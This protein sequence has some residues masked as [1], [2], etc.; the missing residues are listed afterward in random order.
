MNQ[1]LCK[2]GVDTPISILICI[3]QST[4]GLTI[5]NMNNFMLLCHLRAKAPVGCVPTNPSLK[6]GVSDGLIRIGLLS[7]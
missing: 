7:S 4:S 5:N 6:A 2:I 1:Y 3:S